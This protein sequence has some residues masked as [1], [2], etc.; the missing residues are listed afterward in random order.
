MYGENEID[1]FD[2]FDYA[3]LGDIHLENQILDQKGRYPIRRFNCSTKFW[4]I[5]L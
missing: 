5:N 3:M 4:R 1:I 2:K